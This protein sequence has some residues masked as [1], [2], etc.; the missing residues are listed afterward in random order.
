[1][2]KNDYK[3]IAEFLAAVY[4]CHDEFEK[5]EEYI[6]SKLNNC[7]PRAIEYSNKRKGIKK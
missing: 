3:V 6:Y 7:L 4:V 5:T 2:T 1:M